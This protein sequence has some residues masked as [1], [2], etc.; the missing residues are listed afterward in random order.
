MADLPW[1]DQKIDFKKDQETISSCGG[2]CSVFLDCYALQGI[3]GPVRHS[4]IPA[5]HLVHPLLLQQCKQLC[6]D[7]VSEPLSLDNWCKSLR[8]MPLSFEEKQII[9]RRMLKSCKYTKFR[10]V[11]FK[12]LAWI[13]VTPKILAGV[14]GNPSLTR[15]LWCGEEANLEHILLHCSLVQRIKSCI[16]IANH[17]PESLF[18]KK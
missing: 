7:S 18:R 9:F 5:S 3:F 6:C 16:V 11:N 12:I 17:L 1:C 8:L 15:C 10:E 13:L 2:L 14:H 4:L